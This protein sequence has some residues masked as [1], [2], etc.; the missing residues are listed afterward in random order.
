MKKLIVKPAGPEGRFEKQWLWIPE[1]RRLENLVHGT[2]VQVFDAVDEVTGAVVYENIAVESRRGEMHVV[3]RQDDAHV[4]LV[5]HR[6]LS[7]IPPAVSLREFAQD[8][9]KVLSVLELGSGIEEYEV[10]HGL[11]RGR[12]DE[13]LEEIGLGVIESAFLGSIKDSPPLGGVA[14]EVFAVMVGRDVSFRQKE[15]GEE[16]QHVKF[17]PPEE[18]KNIPTICGMTQA[19]LWRFRAWGL[20]QPARTLWHITAA[21]L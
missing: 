5:F 1:R 14:H 21:K 16:I 15:S 4:G 8:S 6:R 17:F 12:L 9:G 7:V 11:A 13:V 10:S 20:A 2:A 18:V 19:G 3:I